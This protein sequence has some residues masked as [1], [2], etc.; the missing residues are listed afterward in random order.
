MRHVLSLS[1]GTFSAAK[2]DFDRLLL[3]TLNRMKTQ[4]ILEGSIT[5]RIDVSLMQQ[6]PYDEDGNMREIY[7]PSFTH[8]VAS[9]LSV[10]DKKKGNMEGDFVLEVRDGVPMLFD[11][12]TDNLFD[13]V[14]DAEGGAEDGA[15]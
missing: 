9:A 1:G 11:R 4:E 15:C 12:D 2:E 10:K 13:R 3:N 7:V 5:L 14:A 6:F 8:E